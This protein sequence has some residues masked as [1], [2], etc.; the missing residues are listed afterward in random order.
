MGNNLSL[1][2]RPVSYARGIQ[3][4]KKR[5]GPPGGQIQTCA[6]GH[7]EQRKRCFFG[8]EKKKKVSEIKMQFFFWSIFFNQNNSFLYL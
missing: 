1:R 3:L 5:T 8:L 7:S 6:E 2:I 4:S